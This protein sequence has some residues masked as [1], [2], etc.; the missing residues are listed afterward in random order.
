M[1]R[2]TASDLR[3]APCVVIAAF[4]V[5]VLQERR[6]GGDAQGGGRTKDVARH[7]QKCFRCGRGKPACPG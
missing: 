5:A 7:C 1:H 2:T 4:H 3:S 6:H